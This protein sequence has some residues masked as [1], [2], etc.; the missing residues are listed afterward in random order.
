M[1]GTGGG[2][3]CLS[4]NTL[5][6]VIEEIWNKT[7]IPLFISEYDIFT[8]NDNVQKQCYQEQISYFMENEHIAGITIWGYIYG[9]T[10]ND[11]TSGIIKD[12]K[13]R[14]ANDRPSDG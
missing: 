8:S 4:I 5:K 3:S 13:D 11:G 14:P 12:N 6:S 10:W 9:A 7:E 1:A 2:G